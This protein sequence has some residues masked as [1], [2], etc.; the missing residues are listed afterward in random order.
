MTSFPP[1]GQDEKPQ[2]YFGIKHS[3]YIGNL[4][5]IKVNYSI[6]LTMFPNL[7]VFCLIKNSQ[8]PFA[9]WHLCE[10]QDRDC[11]GSDADTG[12]VQTKV[13]TSLENLGYTFQAFIYVIPGQ[14]L[15]PSW[16]GPPWWRRSGPPASWAK[17][18]PEGREEG[19]EQSGAT[20]LTPYLW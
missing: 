12:G 19:H 13:K 1:S 16:S 18:W 20:T 2:I 14:G 4:K 8:C 10:E 3:P 7:Q 6:S 11:E 5:E 9:G 17:Q 15:L